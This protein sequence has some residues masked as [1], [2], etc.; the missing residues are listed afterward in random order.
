[1]N[2]NGTFALQVGYPTR[3]GLSDERSAVAPVLVRRHPR[4]RI[5]NFWMIVIVIVGAVI[6]VA[7]GLTR[8]SIFDRKEVWTGPL[9][10]APY[11]GA[12]LFAGMALPLMIA[13]SRKARVSLA[14]GL[15]LWFA[16]CT[17]AYTR[18]FSYVRLPG[19]PL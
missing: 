13:Y 19:A 11:V 18:D 16:F 15:F 9:E 4:T 1:M 10:Y 7:D 8:T 3:S 12:V 17:I 6:V 2:R 5:V 14:E